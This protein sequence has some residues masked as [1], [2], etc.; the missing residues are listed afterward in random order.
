[1]PKFSSKHGDREQLLK[2]EN[3]QGGYTEEVGSTLMALDNLASCENMLYQLKKNVS[4]DPIVT[5]KKRQGTTK[6]SNTA[7]PS[8][9]DVLACYYYAKDARH[10]IL[11]TAAKVYELDGTNDPAEIGA[12]A[13][14]PTF[15]EFHDKLMIFDGGEIIGWTGA[16]YADV[17]GA[18]KAKGGLVRG[19]R[20]Y[21]WGS[22]DY[23]YRLYYSNVNDE[24][25]WSY[26][27][28]D[29]SD[30]YAIIGCVD[31]YQSMVVIKENRLYR[32]DNFP[33]D[34]SFRVEPL[35]DGWGGIAY[36][37][38]QGAGNLISFLSHGQWLGLTPT[39]MYG[40]VQKFTPLSNDFLT[41]CRKYASSLAYAGYNGIDNQLWLTLHDGT[42]YSSSIYVIN[43]DAGNLMSKYKF[44]FTATS[45]CW[46]GG[47]MLIGGADGHLYKLSRT[48]DINY[49]DNAVSYASDTNL[50]TAYTN[51]GMPHNYKHC[52]AI[53]IRMDAPNGVDCDFRLYK[54]NEDSYFYTT[55]IDVSSHDVYI[56]DADMYIYIADWDIYPS[57][58]A[59]TFTFKKR[60]NFMN[61]QT[62]WA[63]IAS[64]G[65]V[66]I[67][68]VNFKAALK[69]ALGGV[70]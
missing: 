11:A 48:E 56:Y 16:A 64:D 5:A 54:N 28:V 13:A 46:A 1:M 20:L 65:P 40:D 67:Y 18:P 10:Y 43:L 39:Q 21:A 15:C 47:V 61:I 12:V 33:G 42:N 29:P 36:R 52:K 69:G 22:S 30:G 37:T 17:A 19:T 57:D 44:A 66:E 63:N 70:D 4:G 32:I 9:A 23:P 35:I 25:T 51:F 34:A 58:I 41:V 26:L 59:S 24:T 45:Y 3:F 38:V 68:G 62:E 27:D 31:F 49:E 53:N 8:S 50:K 6:I 7:L 14:T 55:D 60:F 2:I